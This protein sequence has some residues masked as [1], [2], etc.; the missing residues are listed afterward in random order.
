MTRWSIREIIDALYAASGAGVEVDLVIRG[1][2]CL[3]PGVPGLSER[4]RV[5]S[6]I[7]GSSTQPYLCFGGGT[8]CRIARPGLHLVRQHD[9]A[10]PRP[11]RRSSVARFSIRPWHEQVI[12]QIMA[13][14]SRQ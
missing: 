5:K 2:C 13:A 7:A 1:I 8:A 4:I 11:P 6:I 12:D 14:I 10:Q 3:R 9:A